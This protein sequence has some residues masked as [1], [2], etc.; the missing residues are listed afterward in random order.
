MSKRK[1]K[2]QPFSPMRRDLL[3]DPKWRKLSNKAKVIYLYLRHNSFNE[4]KKIMLPYSQLEDM[5]CP[6]TISNGFRELQEAGFINQLYR[7]GMNGNPSLYDFIGP[8][9]D[10]FTSKRNH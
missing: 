6:Q 9:A 1:D 10:P 2:L 3:K 5:M 4:T 7:G 8:Y